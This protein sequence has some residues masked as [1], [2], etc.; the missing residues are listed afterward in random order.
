MIAKTIAIVSYWDIV[1]GLT[2]YQIDV[3]IL[4]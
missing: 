1:S 4:D 3:S 2:A